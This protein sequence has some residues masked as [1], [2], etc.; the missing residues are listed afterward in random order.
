MRVGK[1]GDGLFQLGGHALDLA[2]PNGTLDGGNPVRSVVAANGVAKIHNLIDFSPSMMESLIFD[3]KI[4]RVA[5]FIG[6]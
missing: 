1:S 3:R 5:C 2:D 4:D 6:T